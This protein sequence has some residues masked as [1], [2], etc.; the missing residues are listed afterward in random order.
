M[1]RVILASNSKPN[2]DVFYQF[3]MGETYR[4][5]MLY[6]GSVFYKVV[7]R[8]EYTVTMQESHI[9]EDD[10]STVRDEAT[11]FDIHVQKAYDNNLN[12]IGKVES[13]VMWEYRGEHGYL[14]ANQ[15]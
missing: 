7:D 6:G 14:Y 8:T 13:I 9:S 5:E 10:G 2:D 11:I 4:A 3:V 15:L 1:K 12:V